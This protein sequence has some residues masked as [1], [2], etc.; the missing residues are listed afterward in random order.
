M[1]LYEMFNEVKK[2][3][4]PLTPHITLAYYNVHGFHSEIARKLEALVYK[5][6]DLEMEFEI[7]ISTQNLYYQKFITM[8]DYITII[9]CEK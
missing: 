3:N 1:N 5:L 8:N 4:Y 9:S 2:L 7:E 6:N